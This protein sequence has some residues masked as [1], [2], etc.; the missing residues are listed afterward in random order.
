MKGFE[1][2]ENESESHKAIWR[3][4]LLRCCICRLENGHT[5]ADTF[6]YNLTNN[7]DSLDVTFD[8]RSFQESF[9]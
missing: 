3:S 8:L 2:S 1:H 5:E 4:V 9:R 7:L 6:I